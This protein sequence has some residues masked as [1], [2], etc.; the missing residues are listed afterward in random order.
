MVNLHIAHLLYSVF[1]P[2][3]SPLV[4]APMCEQHHRNTNI[5][6]TYVRM[7]VSYSVTT[8]SADRYFKFY[9]TLPSDAFVNTGRL[10]LVIRF[11]WYRIGILHSAEVEHVSVSHHTY[12]QDTQ[13]SFSL[14][15]LL[16]T[17]PAIVSDKVQ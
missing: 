6:L 11:G 15:L 13:F 10:N 3:A 12:V 7:Q 8:Q 5:A 17:L 16:I 9:R 4:P 14:A 1:T 2:V